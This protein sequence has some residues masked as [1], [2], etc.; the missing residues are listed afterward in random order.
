M[1]TLM[2]RREHLVTAMAIGILIIMSC[3]LT[4]NTSTIRNNLIYGLL[5]DSW[6]KVYTVD[7]IKFKILNNINNIKS[8]KDYENSMSDDLIEDKLVIENIV[9]N[10][11]YLVPRTSK[12]SLDIVCVLN[13]DVVQGDISHYKKGDFLKF[14][15]SIKGVTVIPETKT[16][17]ARIECYQWRVE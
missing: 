1:K 12:D 9:D 14:K 17:V 8:L 7:T 13:T 6:R 11:I 5:D 4:L 16:K 10:K 3:I 2:L 15:A